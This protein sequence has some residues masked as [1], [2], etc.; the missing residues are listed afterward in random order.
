MTPSQAQP[1]AED[2]LPVFVV[3]GGEGASGAQVVRTAL[4]QFQAAAV[5]VVIISRVRTPAQVDQAVERA[6][7]SRGTLVHTLV[8]AELRRYLAARARQRHVVAIDLMGRL[9]N[10]LSGLLGQ[11]PAGR[12]G[13]Y[14]QLHEEYLERVDALEFAVAHD[15]GRRSEELGRA[16]AVLVGVSRVGKTPLCMYLALQGW[17]A[18]NVPLVAG[19]PPPAELDQADPRRVVG[20]M[21]SADQLAYHR[22]LRGPHLPAPEG[23]AYTDPEQL[24]E[25]LAMA[26]RLY[27]EKGYPVVWTTN[28]PVEE[29]AE[30]VIAVVLGRLGERPA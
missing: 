11:E 5:P 26:R 18:A 15:D 7:A 23:S 4:A 13:L 1:D 17:K 25:E 3:S 29:S 9:L 10:R 19:V 28:K 21:I 22:R 8:D 6:A 2:P 27:Q 24:R 30:E 12:P 16:D 20:L 14:R